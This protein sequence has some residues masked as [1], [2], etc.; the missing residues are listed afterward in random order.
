MRIELEIIREARE[1]LAFDRQAHYVQKAEQTAALNI[2]KNEIDAIESEVWRLKRSI[3]E[4]GKSRANIA[5]LLEIV[6]KRM[7]LSGG[8]S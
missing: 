8:A 6:K 7:H 4:G 3:E 1:R 2:R 5:E